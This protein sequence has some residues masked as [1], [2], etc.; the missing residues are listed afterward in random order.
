MGAYSYTEFRTSKDG[1]KDPVKNVII[2]TDFA[3]DKALQPA[4]DRASL[5]GTAVNATRT[6]VNQPPSH[7]YPES[8]ADAAK[9]LSKGLPVKVTGLGREAPRKGG[10]RR[11]PRRRQGLHPPAAPGQGRVRPGESH[12]QDRPRRQGH[13]LRHRRPL[14]QA[15]PGHGRHEERHGAAPPSSSPP[16]WP[17]AGLACRSRRPRGSASPRTCPPAPPSAPTTS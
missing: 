2:L 16:S 12:G 9:E 6:L 8:F 14:H 17:L 10:L 13:H 5:I 3:A 4:L 15:G 11:H 7:L 1:L